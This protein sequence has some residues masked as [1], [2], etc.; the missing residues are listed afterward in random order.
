MFI[1]EEA[2]F[3]FSSLGSANLMWRGADESKRIPWTLGYRESTVRA[4]LLDYRHASY[5]GLPMY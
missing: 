3:G 5:C 1:F 2:L 4:I